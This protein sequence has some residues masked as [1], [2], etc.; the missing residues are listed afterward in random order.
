[1]A[2]PAN[3][4]HSLTHSS[5]TRSFIL[6]HSLTFTHALTH[7]FITRS[8]IL[9]HSLVHS[10]SH[11]LVHL[12]THSSTTR[13]FIHP[14]PAHSFS[15]TLSLIHHPLVHPH[16]LTRSHP[17]MHSLTHPS[18]TRSFTLIHSLTHS[19]TQLLPHS[20][21]LTHALIHIHSFTFTLTHS[22]NRLSQMQTVPSTAPNARESAPESF[23]ALGNQHQSR[24]RLGPGPAEAD[25]GALR[26][27]PGFHF[28]PQ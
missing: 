3:K 19:F 5:I 11:P 21:T 13:S 14:P 9:I 26:P 17:L 7:S 27:S 24:P 15:F 6:T 25:S 22:F 2:F 16:S 8:F 20:F 18:S 4:S 1:M 28:M 12:P 23:G 10:R